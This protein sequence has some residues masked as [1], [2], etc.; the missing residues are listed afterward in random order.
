MNATPPPAYV[1]THEGRTRMARSSG[2]WNSGT[3]TLCTDYASPDE[4]D[5]L[6]RVVVQRHERIRFRLR[7]APKEVGLNLPHR[8]ITL[9]ASKRPTWR[10]TGRPRWLVLY[11][12]AKRGGSASYAISVRVAS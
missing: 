5:D 3:S 2:C 12:T 7:F 1:V 11:A 9:R 6:P 4:R 10:V 8:S